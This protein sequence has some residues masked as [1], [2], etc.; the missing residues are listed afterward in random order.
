MTC[1]LVLFFVQ[2]PVVFEIEILLT[3]A[4]NRYSSVFRPIKLYF[5]DRNKLKL[6][7]IAQLLFSGFLSLPNLLFYVASPRSPLGNEHQ[8]NHN[9]SNT[10]RYSFNSFCVVDRQYASVYAYYQL[11]LFALFLLN[12]FL[13]TV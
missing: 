1:K 10:P 7:V 6:T 12:L 3:I 8:H 9:H 5:V 2:I 13:I 4:I 11:V